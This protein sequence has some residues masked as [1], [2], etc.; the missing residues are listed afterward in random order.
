MSSPVRGSP[1]LLTTSLPPAVVGSPR[2]VLVAANIIGACLPLE[3]EDEAINVSVV[4]DER[5][6][7]IVVK[8]P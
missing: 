1:P 3:E 6:N 5:A 8:R 4:G 2:I 7:I